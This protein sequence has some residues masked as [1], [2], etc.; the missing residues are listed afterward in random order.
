MGRAYSLMDNKLFLIDKYIKTYL[1]FID[2]CTLMHPE[3]KDFF[4]K[5][6][7]PKLED[8]NSKYPKQKTGFYIINPVRRTAK[9][10]VE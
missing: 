9:Q 6:L 3:A 7:V 10:C 8:Y 4:S 5:V 2:T 1:M